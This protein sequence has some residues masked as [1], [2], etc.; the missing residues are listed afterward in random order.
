[1]SGS[2]SVSALRSVVRKRRLEP[3]ETESRK[4]SRA[5][6]CSYVRPRFI[7][8]NSSMEREVGRPLQPLALAYCWPVL[9][10]TSQQVIPSSMVTTHNL[11]RPLPAI[12]YNQSDEAESVR[13]CREIVQNLLEYH[14][15]IQPIEEFVNWNPSRKRKRDESDET[16]AEEPSPKRRRLCPSQKSSVG[17]IM[18]HIVECILSKCF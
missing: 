14:A 12:Y 11:L 15:H 17:L 8:Q 9:P 16:E 4:R 3:T 2:Q 6:F 7:V 18:S 1:M 13:I 5:E 10:S